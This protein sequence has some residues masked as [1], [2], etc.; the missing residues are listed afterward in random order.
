MQEILIFMISIQLV[1][2]VL[3]NLYVQEKW[4]FTYFIALNTNIWDLNFLDSQLLQSHVSVIL[5]VIYVFCITHGSHHP[6]ICQ[7]TSLITDDESI[8]LLHT[9]LY[10]TFLC[11]IL[12][13][14]TLINSHLFNPYIA[15]LPPIPMYF[16]LIAIYSLSL[17][18][19]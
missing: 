5:C 16:R 7:P 2:Y 17:T 6:R 9:P 12:H 19:V 13:L 10:F 3:L 18:I 15:W 11:E 8:F 1:P 4:V 14:N